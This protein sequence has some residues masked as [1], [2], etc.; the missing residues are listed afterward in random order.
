MHLTS[1]I[2]TTVPCQGKTGVGSEGDERQEEEE[3]ASPHAFQAEKDSSQGQ[4]I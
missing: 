4:A 1:H 2:F 3:I